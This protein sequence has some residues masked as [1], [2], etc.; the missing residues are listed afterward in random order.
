VKAERISRIRDSKKETNGPTL[1]RQSTQ[2]KKEK[3]ETMA[4]KR[5]EKV[6]KRYNENNGNQ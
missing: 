6:G 3:E 5:E 2:Q 1:E 4:R